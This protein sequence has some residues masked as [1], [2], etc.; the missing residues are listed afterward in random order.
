[1]ARSIVAYSVEGV[2]AVHVTEQGTVDGAVFLDVLNNEIFPI[3]NPYG[4]GLP[5][6]VLALNNATVHQKLQIIAACQQ[7]GVLA[8]FLPPYS[9]DYNPIEK[10][11][12]QAKA[13][14]HRVWPSDNHNVLVRDRLHQALWNS[15]TAED[16]TG[17]FTFSSRSRRKFGSEAESCEV[18]VSHS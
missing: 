8:L 16:A 13:Y 4:S 9:Y 12:H 10:C 3:M 18:E 14:V 17:Y 6:S 11:F 7:K 15:D 2:Q 5:R 1:M